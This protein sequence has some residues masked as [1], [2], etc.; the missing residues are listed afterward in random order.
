MD[1]G[2]QRR[3]RGRP[4]A[5]L[6][7]GQGRPAR[8]AGDRGRGARRA[9]ARLRRRSD[10]RPLPRRGARRRALRAALPVPEGR[11]LRRARPQRPARRLRHRRR[12]HR[13][14]AHRDRL[15]RGRLPPRPAVRPERRQPGAPRRHLRRA[16]RPLRRAQGQGR[17]P[18]PDRGP[19][20]PR[21]AAAGRDDRARLSALLALGRPA[22][23]L[24]QAVVVHRDLQAARAADRG[25]Q[26]GRLVPR[27]H[28]RGAH[29]RLAARQRRLGAVARA[30]LGHAAARVA[31][32]EATASTRTSSGRSTSSRS[33]PACGWRTRTGRSST[34]SASRARSAARAWSACPR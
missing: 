18:R 8:R 16:H 5:H 22:H 12:R 2:L 14:R 7:A 6:R 15:R 10:P 25:Q 1:A 4:R 34:R 13:P 33:C 9:R 26:R 21:T 24:R 19:P 32:H 20:R 28:P 29:G 23:V 17:R 30:L 31:L 3:G 27:A 11:R